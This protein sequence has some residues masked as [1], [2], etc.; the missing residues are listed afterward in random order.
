MAKVF[1]SRA[2]T[3]EGAMIKHFDHLTIVVG[4]LADAKRFFGLLGFR[5]TMSVVIS[6]PAM[7]AYMGVANIVADHVTLVADGVTPRTEVQLLHYR[8]PAAIED[9]QI[10]DLHKTGLNHVCFAVDDINSIVA[11]M[12]DNG[13]QTRNDIMEFHS[14]KLVFLVGPEGVTIELSQWD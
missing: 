12:R 6:G 7:A 10:R 8:Q 13:Y 9:P 4:D 14:R 3:T 5:E 1:I 2:A 11:M